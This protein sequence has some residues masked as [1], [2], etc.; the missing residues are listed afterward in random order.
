MT[1]VK[2]IQLDTGS[3]VRESEY[4]KIVAAVNS[5]IPT[6]LP[7]HSYPAEAMVGQRIWRTRPKRRIGSIIAHSVRT[8]LLPLRFA[9][10]G[11]RATKLY[12]LRT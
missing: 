7:N 9:D 10:N 4:Q 1:E 5:F 12:E 6:M 2:V 3:S 11:K 8:G